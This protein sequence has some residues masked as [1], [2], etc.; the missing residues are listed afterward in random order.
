MMFAFSGLL[1]VGEYNFSRANHSWQYLFYKA[2]EKPGAHSLMAGKT[3]GSFYLLNNSFV[4]FDMVS[5][6]EIVKLIVTTLFELDAEMIVIDQTKFYR[7]KSDTALTKD[8]ID[9]SF[10]GLSVQ[11]LNIHEDLGQVDFIFC[12]KTGTLTQNEL[13]FRQFKFVHRAPHPEKD[14]NAV[15]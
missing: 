8:Q 3:F 11:N 10:V 6:I 1:V 4:P 13:I 15:F 7:S 14:K 5:M 12:D 2:F 9:Q